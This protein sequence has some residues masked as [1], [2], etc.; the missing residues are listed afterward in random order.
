[1]IE[2]PAA[3]APWASQL[4]MLPTDLALAVAPWV[5]RL[6][7]AVGPLSEVHHER[8][9]EPDG[10]R[11]LTRRGSY[12][13]LVTAEW[14]IAE[15]F[16]DEFLRR[17][18]AGEH[19][20]LDLARRGPRGA[21]RSIALVSAGPAQ[22]GTPRLAH[23]AILV[24]LARRAALANARFSWGILED[25]DHRLFDHVSA[26][27]IA[28][29]LDART[30]HAGGREAFAA[31]RVELS[32]LRDVWF[33]GGEQEASIAHDAGAC[34][35]IVRDVLEPDQRAIDVDVYRRGAPAARVRLALPAPELCVRLLR[36]PFHNAPLPPQVRGTLAPHDIRF[37]AGGR[38][39]IVRAGTAIESWPVPSSLRDKVGLPKRTEI[40]HGSELVAVGTG[41]RA[42]LAVTATI[43]EPSSVEISY[44]SNWR[45]RVMLPIQVV[46]ALKRWFARGAAEIG[47]CGLVKVRAAAAPDL[48]M[49]IAGHLLVVLDFKPGQHVEGPLTALPFSSPARANVVATAFHRDRVLWAERRDETIAVVESSSR[50]NHTVTAL[51]A[52]PTSRVLF[53]WSPPWGVVAV[54]QDETRW[55]VAAPCVSPTTL[56]STAPVIGVCARDGAPMLLVQIHAHRLAWVGG[57][58]ELLPGSAASIVATAVSADTPQVAWL[59]DV[60]LLNIFS[61]G[62]KQIIGRLYFEAKS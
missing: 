60:G 30:A 43:G 16:P 37:A 11:G 48:V 29:L 12:E 28:R 33:V 35:I 62:A 15:L 44:G 23:L 47:T 34:S 18:G 20:F 10:Y 14:G 32:A 53:G 50:G 1:M 57:A 2:L 17:A 31:W 49:D 58:G 27:S 22:L 19:L 26:L 9:G 6:A 39:V 5:G 54:S 46:V 52:T 21:Q 61:I 4:S 59:T 51:P 55:M 56:V 40:P 8:T 42:V 3:L 24:V 25:P 7:L 38:R 41:R 13:R 45:T 36:D